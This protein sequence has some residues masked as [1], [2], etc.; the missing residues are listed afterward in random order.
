GNPG[1]S[2]SSILTLEELLDRQMLSRRFQT[3]LIGVFS[4]I[5]LALAAL[6][7]FAVMHYS[8]AARMH[9]IGIRMAVGAGT[10]D[11]F[12]LVLADGVGLAGGGVA[13]GWG[14]PLGAA[15]PAAGLLYEVNP[16]APAS[17]A[18]AA[19]VLVVAA[20]AACC[21]PA[22]RATRMDPLVALRGD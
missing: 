6:G 18:T 13:V 20:L 12:K 9:E 21:F 3:W 5:A 17:F 7:V 14:G 2:I 22:V 1:V 19:A 15:E 11:L 4:T 16:G 8:V 10:G